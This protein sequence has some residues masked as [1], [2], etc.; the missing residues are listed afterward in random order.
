MLV[1]IA[2][3]SSASEAQGAK[4]HL[5]QVG[6]PAILE[7]TV[8]IDP[9]SKV[10]KNLF[11]LKVHLYDQA[12]AQT[13]LNQATDQPS[14]S[15]P[16]PKLLH[17]SITPLVPIDHLTPN[18]AIPFE[19]QGIHQDVI[20]G[21]KLLAI[22]SLMLWLWDVPLN[23]GYWLWSA[24]MLA[25]TPIFVPVLGQRIDAFF[26]KFSI[27][28]LLLIE[29]QT[30]PLAQT[31]LTATKTSAYTG[32]TLVNT[33]Q[34]RLNP[35]LPHAFSTT[36]VTSTHNPPAPQL[37]PPEIRKETRKES[38]IGQWMDHIIAQAGALSPEPEAANEPSAMATP[39]AQPPETPQV[40]TPQEA[41]G[42]QLLAILQEMGDTRPWRVD[43]QQG[44]LLLIEGQGLVYNKRI[45]DELSTNPKALTELARAM[46]YNAP[47]L[48]YEDAKGRLLP[49]LLP[50]LERGLRELNG[51]PDNF[52]TQ[53][54]V[55][56]FEVSLTFD[57]VYRL[58]PVSQV[59]L[60]DWGIS[61]AEA[62]ATAYDNLY[63]RSHKPLRQ[64]SAGLWTADWQDYADASRILLP[65]VLEG[66]AVKG[67][68]VVMIPHRNQLFLTGDQD[69]AA[70][71]TL[72]QKAQRWR[73]LPQALSFSLWR[74]EAKGWRPFFPDLFR[75]QLQEWAYH[76]RLKAYHAQHQAL[77]AWHEQNGRHSFIADFKITREKHAPYEFKSVSFWMLD[78][79]RWLPQVDIVMIG[80]PQYGEVLLV[81]WSDLVRIC[82]HRMRLLDIY[83]TRFECLGYPNASEWTALAQVNVFPASS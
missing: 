75:I 47:P 74:E 48:R 16:P 21:L 70:I 49:A 82:G 71:Q 56:D 2:Y 54:F 76:D 72:L 12:Q 59:C 68:P 23:T 30:Q 42:I 4:K 43:P 33:T 46:M 73:D 63:Q 79:V 26:D 81:T 65:S 14:V 80:E 13:I 58:L 11:D 39:V 44:R 52:P 6:I 8:V 78:D 61:F 18:E 15:P 10:N 55:E 22:T 32:A 20:R 83:P 50:R 57:A 51:S 37:V 62:M 53:A 41:I 27:K 45:L 19:H 36:T 17:R 25:V 35:P 69:P 67:K 40:L 66:Y 64:D 29:P 77:F 9:H 1:T 24:G 34:T 28:K 31:T 5:D 60:E 3:Y 7:R 38:P